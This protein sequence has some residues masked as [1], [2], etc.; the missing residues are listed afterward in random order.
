MRNAYRLRE[1]GHLSDKGE[2]KIFKLKK[3]YLLWRSE[4]SFE[5]VRQRRN[6]WFNILFHKNTEILFNLKFQ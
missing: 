5:H 1:I 4:D 2:D 6:K 3:T